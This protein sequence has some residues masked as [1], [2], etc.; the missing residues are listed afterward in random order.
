[1]L[2]TKNFIGQGA[3]A[4]SN[5]VVQIATGFKE[6]SEVTK[7]LRAEAEAAKDIID[8]SD[9]DFSIDVKRIYSKM[10]QLQHL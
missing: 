1:M 7:N 6:M 3:P 9:P 10:Q 2:D 4:L 5:E 8:T